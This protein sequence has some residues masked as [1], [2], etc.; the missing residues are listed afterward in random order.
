MRWLAALG[1]LA[2]G[3]AVGLASVA[4]H[5]TWWG[6]PLV[7]AATSS[8]AYALPA[9]LWSRVSFALG[10]TGTV[11]WLTV[12]RPEGDY[13]I[14]SNPSGYVLLGFALALVVAAIVTLPP[15]RRARQGAEPKM[16]P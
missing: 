1:L 11:G 4:V 2:V 3:V 14:A 9:G 7:L 8:A 5:E 13:A 10:W 12:P 6:L 15:P 16:T